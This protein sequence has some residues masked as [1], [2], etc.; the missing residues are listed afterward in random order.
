MRMNTLFNKLF[1]LIPVGVIGNIIYSIVFTDHAVMGSVV[2]Y[3]PA[4]LILA[5][6][7]CI[8][9]WFTGS[10]RLF[11]WSK[12]L[13]KDQRYR[14][15]FAIAIGAELGAAASPPVVG[16]GP[17]KTWMLMQRGFSGGAA[18]SLTML[19][20]FEDALFFLVMVPVALTLSSAWDLPVVRSSTAGFGHLSFWILPGMASA[21]LLTGILVAFHRSKGI[22]ERF[23]RLCRITG[24][25]RTS[26]HEFVET[27]H[28][29]VLKGK[30]VF[31]LTMALTTIQ[32]VC[33]Y[34]I[35]SLLLL[36]LGIA[37][38]PLLFMALQVI[39][40][41]LLTFIPTPGGVGG[42]E[43]LFFVIY[44]SFLPPE[45]IGIV[46]AGWRFFTFYLLLLLAAGLF[47]LFRM[48][49]KEAAPIP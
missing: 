22:T 47:F 38:R 28:N 24:H 2:R 32:W 5:L 39:V 15:M 20:G 25:L 36:G 26:Y 23:P 43:A 27:Y 31:A 37:P 30:T 6:L 13:G 45:T 42:A 41:A 40:F 18:L 48:S 9:P 35:I 11:I 3:S 4:Y 21:V 29:I 34:S 17:I 19:E 33:R 46:T 44:R 1:F 7:L 14:D 8:V 10:F 49:P 16:G 12:F